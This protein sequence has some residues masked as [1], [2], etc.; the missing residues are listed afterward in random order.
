MMDIIVRGSTQDIDFVQRICRDKVRRGM[1][2]ILPATG[3]VVDDVVK[4]REERD[5]TINLLRE[6]ETRIGELENRIKELEE[7]AINVED[8]AAPV[9]SE[10]E[11]ADDKNLDFVEDCQEV[12][13][14]DDKNVATTDS[15]AVD[16][17]TTD[18]PATPRKR[19]RRPK[20]E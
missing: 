11:M 14:E 12:I 3:P 20:T 1:I 17:E 15:K 6:R 7:S 16:E 5:E 8:E 13:L 18:A 2:T 19:G 4:L 9:D 10:M